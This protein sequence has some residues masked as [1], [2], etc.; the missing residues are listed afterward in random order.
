MEA[1]EA[2]IELAQGTVTRGYLTNSIIVMVPSGADGLRQAR[3]IERIILNA[4]LVCEIESFNAAEVILGSL[5]G[6]SMA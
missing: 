2:Q 4:G 5:P 3:E 6:E 1:E